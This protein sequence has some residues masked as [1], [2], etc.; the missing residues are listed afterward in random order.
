MQ[1]IGFGALDHTSFIWPVLHARN[2]N[3]S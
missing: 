3:G 1:L 2:V